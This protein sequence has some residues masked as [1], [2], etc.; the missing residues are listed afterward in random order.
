MHAYIHRCVSTHVHPHSLSLI[1]SKSAIQASKEKKQSI[2]LFNSGI[3][4]N[5]QNCRLFLKGQW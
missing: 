3:C 4:N 5:D 2:V 1:V